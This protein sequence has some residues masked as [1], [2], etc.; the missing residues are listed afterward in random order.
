[1]AFAI[2]IPL[3]PFGTTPQEVV[4]NFV[5]ENLHWVK[6]L[7]NRLSDRT[8]ITEFTTRDPRTRRNITLRLTAEQGDDA[9][10]VALLLCLWLQKGQANV[11]DE[12]NRLLQNLPVGL[13]GEC[14]CVPASKNPYLQ[15]S[16]GYGDERGCD[17]VAYGE[18]RGFVV[19]A[20]MAVVAGAVAI[21]FIGFCALVA[22]IVLPGL[23]EI[24]AVALLQDD[25]YKA[26]AD[27]AEWSGNPETAVRAASVVIGGGLSLLPSPADVI[28]GVGGMVVNA[29][30]GGTRN[31]ANTEPPDVPTAGI[32]P[33]L[34]VSAVVV[35]FLVAS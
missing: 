15:E 3:L 9:N 13:E 22:V 6:N 31:G 21:T 5:G 20:T 11:I 29:T 27:G 25:Y 26:T 12:A 1:M 4:S 19:T 18:E 24:A 10:A 8:G 35:L 28:P 32:S 16:G 17:V 2:P 30:D 23:M 34:I 7:I 14:D 33:V